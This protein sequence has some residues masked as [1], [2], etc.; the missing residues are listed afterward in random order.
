V[1]VILRSAPATVTSWFP[2]G[3]PKIA[4]V[5]LQFNEVVQ[6]SSARGGAPIRYVDSKDF[7][8]RGKRYRSSVSSKYVGD[9]FPVA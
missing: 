5:S 9:T 7:A 4:S 1:L 3:S 6:R 8:G 2:D